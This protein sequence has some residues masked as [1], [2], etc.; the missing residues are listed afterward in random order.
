MTFD[1]FVP[2]SSSGPAVAFA[3]EVP[4]AG[5][6]LF[7]HGPVGSGKSHLLH[8]IA[9]A[10]R[11]RRPEANVVHLAARA[12]VEMLAA[13]F[14]EPEEHAFHESMA[15]A[16]VL[17]LDDLGMAV[18]NQPSTEKSLYRDVRALIRRDVRVAIASDA[19]PKYDLGEHAAVVEL[20]YPDKAGRIEILRRATAAR[21]LALSDE[22]LRRLAGRRP[23]SPRELQSLAARLAA[24]AA[25]T[26]SPPPPARAR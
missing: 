25:L 4:G 21:K 5:N 22:Q 23:C 3:D 7:L 24:E 9:H 2:A 18:R 10:V 12:Y 16:G 11:T 6:P 8:A 20:A 17:L 15:A 26:P 1:F 13:A 14:R 19:P